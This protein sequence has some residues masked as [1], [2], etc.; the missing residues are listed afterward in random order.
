MV[1]PKA[2]VIAL[3][4]SQILTEVRNLSESIDEVN[5]DCDKKEVINNLR[6][7]LEDVNHKRL[8]NIDKVLE[9]KE[10]KSGKN[11][12]NPREIKIGVEELNINY[13]SRKI[14]LWQII[15]ILKK[16]FC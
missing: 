8:L 3:K 9:S 16:L 11:R 14:Q 13:W 2:A 4:I 6:S 1:N 5:I 10:N 12:P 15:K 7:Q